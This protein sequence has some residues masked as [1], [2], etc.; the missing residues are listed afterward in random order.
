MKSCAIS[1][2]D[3]IVVVFLL[4]H[5]QFICRIYILPTVIEWLIV[6]CESLSEMRINVMCPDIN[7]VYLVAPLR[8]SSRV[9]FWILGLLRASQG[10]KFL[11]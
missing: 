6:R 10:I 5:C 2:L 4:I 1:I 3:I 8:L 7:R 9:N 11:W